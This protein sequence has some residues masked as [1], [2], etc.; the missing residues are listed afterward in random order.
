MEADASGSR[1]KKQQKLGGVDRRE[2]RVRFVP[3]RAFHL[4][5]G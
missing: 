3:P 4:Q 2:G 1:R 5:R